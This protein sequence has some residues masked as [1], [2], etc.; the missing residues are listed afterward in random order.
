MPSTQ[1]QACILCNLAV[2]KW[3]PCSYLG[4]FSVERSEI[5]YVEPNLAA[6][7]A[8]LV[9]LFRNVSHNVE[10]NGKHTAFA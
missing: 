1:T 4:R 2:A 9:V 7:E 6:Q 5:W 10:I 3:Q 8:I